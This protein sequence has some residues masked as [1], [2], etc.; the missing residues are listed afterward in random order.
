MQGRNQ[1]YGLCRGVFR[2]MVYAGVYS[3][4]WSMQGRIQ[5]YGLCRGLF[6]YIV[7]AGVYSGIWSKQGR[8]QVYGLCRGVFRNFSKG[9]VIFFSFYGGGAGSAPS[10]NHI[11]YISGSMEA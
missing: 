8:I 7:Y 5:V 9:G 11:F 6:R 10:E 4:I 2:Y 1:V 3:G